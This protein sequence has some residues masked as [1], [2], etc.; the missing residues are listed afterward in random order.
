[1]TMFIKLENGQPIGNAVSQANL[2]YLFPNFNF[3]QILTPAM[4]EPL[5][6]GIYEFTQ[7]PTVQRYEK[8]VEGTAIRNDDNGIYYQNWQAQ[9]MTAEEQQQ[10]DLRRADLMRAERNAMLTATDWTQLGDAQLTAEKRAEYTV[11]RQALRDIPSSAG[12]P[13]N[14]TWPTEPA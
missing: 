13:W 8:I 14:T 10:T 9:A 7:I 4:V 5:G 3:N 6:Y 12:F 2:E 1:M 11:Y